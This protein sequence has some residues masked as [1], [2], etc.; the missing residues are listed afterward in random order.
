MIH[1]YADWAG[2][3]IVTGRLMI[4]T[5]GQSDLG[6]LIMQKKRVFVLIVFL[7]LMTAGCSRTGAT[8][9][10]PDT[11]SSVAFKTPEEA[12]THYFEGV[13]QGDIQKIT[14][15]CAI[16][17]MSEKFKFEQSTERLRVFLPVESE[18]PAEYPLYVE[19]NKTQLSSQ[20]FSRVKMFAYSL[21]SSENVAEGAAI[22]LD[23]GG[24]ERMSQFT[25][26]VDPRGLAQLELKKIGLPDKKIM[27]DS[28]YL[29]NAAELASIYGAD[30]STE[31]VA[32]FSFKG[33]YYYLGFT[34]LRYGDNWKIS[35]QT[36]PLAGI[37][38][39]GTPQKTTVEEFER[40]T[41]SN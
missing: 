3:L 27:N 28:R 12:I 39:L 4:L 32:L 11:A 7:A 15:A 5:S 20:I 2:H 30:E 23:A 17:E 19:I 1:V 26:D 10:A 8:A 31:R 24:T 37:S 41:S 35:S 34:L 6:G 22:Q 40:M 29:A 14:Q 38:S 25:R 16:D 9:A 36:S 13:A 21:L 33:N 18:S